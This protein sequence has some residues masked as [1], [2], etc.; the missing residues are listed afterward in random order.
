[1]RF[2]VGEGP[3]RLLESGGFAV[4]IPVAAN[5]LAKLGVDAA[6]EGRLG[7]VEIR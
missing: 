2:F 4:V 5:D 1:L 6:E 7:L 3:G